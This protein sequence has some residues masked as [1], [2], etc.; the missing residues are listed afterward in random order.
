MQDLEFIAPGPGCWEL[1]TAHHFRPVT[2]FVRE[3]I[4]NAM[5][6][7]F[8]E[9]TAF[10]GLTFSHLRSAFVNGFWYVKQVY[11]GVPE[12]ADGPLPLDIFDGP[13][14]KARMETCLHAFK[15]RSWLEDLRNWD[16]KFKPDSIDRNKRLQEVNLAD[17]QDSALVDHIGNCADNV[18]EMIRRHH[19]FTAGACLPIGHY[20]ASGEAW[21]GLGPSELMELLKGATPISKGPVRELVNLAEAI[22]KAQVEAQIFTSRSALEALQELRSMNDPVGPATEAYLDIIGSSIVSGYDVSAPT[23]IEVPTLL[24]G[25]IQAALNGSLVSYDEN[26][27]LDKRTAVFAKVPDTHKDAFEALLEDARKLFR[28]REERTVYCDQWALGIARHALLEAGGRLVRRGKLVQ[29][30]ELIDA[31]MEEIVRLFDGEAGPSSEELRKRAAYRQSHTLKDAPSWLGRPPDPPFPFDAVPEAG[32]PGAIAMATAL[33]QIYDV[34]DKTANLGKVFGFAASPGFYEGPV[35]IVD[36]AGDFARLRKGDV[37]VTKA[38]SA[39]ISV[40]LPLVGAIVTDRG[41][42]L[43]HPAIIAREYGI[44]GVVG[45]QVA[46]SLFCDG[47][48]VRVDGSAGTV[49]KVG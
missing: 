41:G 40:V 36:G 48:L 47:D 42:R 4:P 17:L 12:D 27:W 45:T 18:R 39:A 6:H 15:T 24:T 5:A 13:S 26:V 9:G 21:T 37:I 22:R 49:E 44:P 2:L 43:S 3:L 38:T 14:M 25:A 23:G 16:E 33:G 20:L 1:E 46:T 35:C 19:R 32:R 10:Y 29:P 8:S 11:A 30:E 31:S 34:Q 7:G 28:L